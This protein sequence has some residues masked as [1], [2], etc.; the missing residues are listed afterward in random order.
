MSDPVLTPSTPSAR[1]SREWRVRLPDRDGED[2]ETWLV[3]HGAI[4][5][6]LTA[7]RD[8]EP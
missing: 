5:N 7:V 4:L 3:T 8:G 2:E 6:K 1:R